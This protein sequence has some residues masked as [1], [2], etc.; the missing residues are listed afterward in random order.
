MMLDQT[1]GTF[2][3]LQSESRHAKEQ[4]NSLGR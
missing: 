3:H 2:A 1:S 4:A